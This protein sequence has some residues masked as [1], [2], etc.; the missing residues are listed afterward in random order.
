MAAD[1]Y[2]NISSRNTR[3]I[4]LELHKIA[5]RKLD[6]IDTAAV[7]EDLKAPPN[8]R[9]EK[10]KGNLSGFYSIKINNQYRI[11]LSWAR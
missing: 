2:D 5:I 11:I 4:P 6:Y 3:K 7:I 9:L 10:L 8:N 1:I